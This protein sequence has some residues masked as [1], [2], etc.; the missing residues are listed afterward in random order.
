MHIVRYNRPSV[1]ACREHF[2]PPS[3]FSSPISSLSIAILIATFLPA[4]ALRKKIKCDAK[5]DVCSSCE[6]LQIPCQYLDPTKK[7]G[8]PKGAGRYVN[9]IEDRLHRMEAMVS[10]VADDE[11]MTVSGDEVGTRPRSS[12]S[13]SASGKPRR[14]KSTKG[15]ADKPAQVAGHK[16][17]ADSDPQQHPHLLSDYQYQHQFQHENPYQLGQQ[18]QQQHQHQFLQGQLSPHHQSQQHHANPLL[19]L[20]LDSS[21]SPDMISQTHSDDMHRMMDPH[22]ITPLHQDLLRD[23]S[24]PSFNSPSPILSSEHS[25][26]EYNDRSP[27]ADTLPRLGL[28][29]PPIHDVDDLEE[30][31]GHLTL[32]HKGHERYVGKSSPMF[33]NRRHWGGYSIRE[34]ELPEARKFVE[35]PDL[36]SPEVMTKLLNLYF[37]YVHPFAPVFVWSKF[38]KRLQTRDYSPSF[39]FLLNSIFALASRFSDDPS[40]RTDPTKPE[41]VGVRFVEKAKAILDTIYDSPDMYC[42]GAL[43]LLSYQ[44]MGT[45]GG[46]RAWMFIGISIRMA[47]HLGLNRDC[48]KLNPHMPALDRE[49]RNRIW[50]TCFVADRIVSA[51]FGRPQGINEHDVDATYPEGID[52][53][54]IQLEYRLEGANSILT[55]PS[56]HSEKNFVYMASLTRIMGR[57]MVSLYSPLSR[58]T[59]MSSSSMTDSAPLEQLD[60]ELT[61]WLLT[62][63]PHLQFRSVQQEPGTFVCTLHMTFYATLILL[64]R[65]YSHQTPYNTPNESS[66]SLSICTSAANNTIEMAGNLMRASDDNRDVPRIKCLLH[67]AVFI[68][69]TAGLVHITNCTSMNPVLAASAKLRT[70]ET[71]RCLSVIEDV[72]ITGKWCGTNI[73][74]LVKARNIELPCSVEG[75]KYT[76][77]NGGNAVS[78]VDDVHPAQ[79]DILPSTNVIPK[80]QSFAFDVDQIM[81]YYQAPG[82]R[83]AEPQGR[84]SRHFS[85][86]PYFSPTSP[87]H[88]QNQVRSHPGLTQGHAPLPRRPRQAK[89]TS[90]SPGSSVSGVASSGPMTSL[91]NGGQSVFSTSQAESMA[92]GMASSHGFY[93]TPLTDPFATPGSA[94]IVNNLQQQHQPQPQ[95]QVRSQTGAESGGSLNMYQNPF[96]STVWNLPT[97]MDNDEWILYMQSGGAVGS[98][99]DANGLPTMGNTSNGNTNNS[100]NSG[101]SNNHNNNNSG[102]SD[103][104]NIQVK[105]ENGLFKSIGDHTNTSPLLLDNNAVNLGSMNANSSNSALGNRMHPLA[106][107]LTRNDL[108]DVVGPMTSGSRTGSVPANQPSQPPHSLSQLAQLP[109]QAQRQ[110][111]LPS[112]GP[113]FDFFM[114]GTN[115]VASTAVLQSQTTVASQNWNT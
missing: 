13:A 46:Y 29:T 73:K 25:V 34:R 22:L 108:L 51:T 44:Q 91:S 14:R 37:S 18:Q 31:M 98:G 94:T 65:P 103:T 23:T 77:R 40:L 20:Q 24:F 64:H 83:H 47:Q 114:G 85:P 69:F 12:S 19:D 90:V 43:V 5:A 111:L 35:N 3:P 66:I 62:L 101:N 63:P 113:E 16:G 17:K 9:S 27:R 28:N 58:A 45:G 78:T 115:E 11:L 4:L 106:Q 32:D 54:N 88:A 92:A 33:Y 110:P 70:V 75:F 68:F 26:G 1:E 86:T 61:D 30:D 109:Q 56:P 57:V 104:D 59:S 41:T 53:E 89:N 36:P 76:L 96:S 7:R 112:Q 95:Q 67:S 49:E 38:L 107:S 71:L 102:A 79:V 8:P 50:W 42:V 81:G 100:G 99:L 39:L 72:W 87:H 80:E 48:M 2:H 55:G 105:M 82:I 21:E 6:L 74:N 52:E 97:S 10:G 60:K 84:N 15:S 93:S